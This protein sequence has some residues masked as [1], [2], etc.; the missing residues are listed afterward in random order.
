MNAASLLPVDPDTLAALRTHLRDTGSE[1]S[2]L[3]S[4]SLAIRA[5]IVPDVARAGVT[6]TRPGPAAPPAPPAAHFAER[7]FRGYQWKE[8][9]L[10]DGTDLRMHFEGEAYHARVTGNGIVYEGRRV[11]PRQLTIAIAGDGRNA[12]RD[13][14]LRLPGDQHFR[15]ACLLRRNEQAK[16]KAQFE[17]GERPPPESP[18]AAIAAAA[19]SMSEALR[20]ALVLVEHSNAQSVPKYERRVDNKRRANDVLAGHVMFD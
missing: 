20:T 4:V 8:L 12:W 17:A 18:A 19:A 14:S 6:G 9:F 2:L 3:A 11:S 16:I 10:P 15:P 13:L 7:G 1:L 5:W